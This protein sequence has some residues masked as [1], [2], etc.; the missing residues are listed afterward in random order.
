MRLS[1]SRPAVIVSSAATLALVASG[2][3]LATSAEA[4]AKPSAAAMTIARQTLAPNDGWASSGTGTT[5]GSTAD[6]AHIFVVH[7][8]AELVT[9]LGGNNA[10]NGS[11]ATPKIIFVD[12]GIKGN[13]D[14]TNKPLTCADYA[15]PAYSFDAFLATYDPAVWGRTTKPSGPLEDARARSAKNQGARVNI[16]VG[17]NTT[18]VGLDGGKFTNVNLFLSKV[19][20]VILRN[21]R[22]EDA[23]DCFPAWDPTDGATG[24]WNSLYDLISLKGAT[25]VW[26]DHSSFS[27]GNN[28]DDNQPLYFGRPFQVHDGALDIT[29]AS[30]LVTASWNNF[31]DHDKTML[32]GST[33]TVGADVGK[34]RVTLHHNRFANVGQRTPRVRFGQVD[35]Y[36]N[37]YYATTEDIYVYSWGVG[38]FSSIYAENNMVLRSAD[39]PLDAVV[40]D[41]RGGQPGG[42]TEVG[43]MTRVGTGPVTAVSFVDAYNQSFDPDLS[44]TDF[45]PTL[46][47]APPDPTDQVQ[48]LV[49]HQAGAGKIGI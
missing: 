37:F 27:D 44:P 48:S 4:G 32:I 29:N 34:L 38:V 41:W 1:L 49:A 47:A 23:A 2:V 12:G 6:D 21:L 15:D 39:I 33:N 18:I 13:V 16:N 24:N 45:V 35:V 43:S 20:N 30:D 17:P 10:T 11:N 25:H 19:N 8:R 42:I 5:G 36:N 31:F 14:D 46:R 7:D 22:L 3:V 26:V 9:A 28:T 40:F